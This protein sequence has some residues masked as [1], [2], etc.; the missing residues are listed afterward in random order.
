VL[1]RCHAVEGLE[2]A[3]EAVPLAVVT[4]FATAPSVL[5]EKVNDKQVPAVILRWDE[6]GGFILRT[7]SRGQFRK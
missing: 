2:R 1:E 3:R 4:P 7:I 6:F 5:P